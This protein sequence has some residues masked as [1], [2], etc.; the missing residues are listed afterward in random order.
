MTKQRFYPH[1]YTLFCDD[2]RIE[3]G[4]KYSAMG[5]YQAVLGIESE[6]INLTKF[7]ALNVLDLPIKYCGKKL[8]IEFL[9]D[10]KSL[11]K[12]SVVLPVAPSQLGTQNHELGMILTIPI[13]AEP[14]EASI[15]D[16][17]FVTIDLDDFH[18]TS[19]P[20]RIVSQSDMEQESL[21]MA[22]ALPYE[23]DM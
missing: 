9:N 21:P 11:S 23:S 17:F 5:I 15:G 12:T 2:V 4:G 20:L 1:A 19:A 3:S 18:Y 14:F 16:N 10:A 22:R 6:R 7:V 8:D 13:V